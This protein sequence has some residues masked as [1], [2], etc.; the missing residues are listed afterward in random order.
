M[1]RFNFWNLVFHR[2]ELRDNLNKA[3]TAHSVCGMGGKYVALVRSAH[4]LQE[5]LDIHKEIWGLGYRNEDLGPNSFGMFRC[6][7]ILKMTPDDVFLG[8]IYGLWTFNI[9]FWESRRTELFGSNDWG[10]D[11]RCPVYSLILDQY[12]RRLLKGIRRAMEES[13]TFL[14]EARSKGYK[15]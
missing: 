9:P 13:D 5:L 3:T 1:K 12:R 4:H 10:V 15:V 2:S 8:N 11:P 7:D 14:L 6:P